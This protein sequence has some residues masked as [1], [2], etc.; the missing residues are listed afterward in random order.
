MFS[1]VCSCLFW[2]SGGYINF[3]RH[4]ATTLSPSHFLDSVDVFKIYTSLLMSVSLPLFQNISEFSKLLGFVACGFLCLSVPKYLRVLKMRQ[5]NFMS[6]GSVQ[7]LL[8]YFKNCSG[9]M[10]CLAAFVQSLLK[11]I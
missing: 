4:A 1:S 9:H 7:S 10:L 6:V 3:A 2:G 8:K 5:S 11:Y